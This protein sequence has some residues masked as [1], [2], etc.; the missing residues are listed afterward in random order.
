MHPKLLDYYNR[1][2]VYM[3]EMS[4][5]FAREHP[6]VAK[7]LGMHG[8]EVAD[9][10]VE[11]LIE[12]FCMMS[13]RMQI[14]L[15]AEFPRLTQ[16]LL[17]VIY[18]SYVAPTPSI[19]VAQ[20]HPGGSSGSL[21]RGFA[22][23]RDTH[24]TAL[25]AQGTSTRCL[26]RTTQEVT[27][28]PLEI[29]AA[30]LTGVPPDIP[31]LARY[32][33]GHVEVRGAIRLKLA[34]R[35]ALNFSS[36]AGLD[37]LPIYLSGDEQVATHLFELLH[38]SA[39]A[40][41]IAEPGGFASPA[42]AVT[43]RPVTLEGFAP[44]QSA[45]PLQW[46]MFHGHNLLQEY[47][48]CP[49]RFYFFALEQLAAGLAR[50]EGPQAELVILLS[51]STDKLASL[52]DASQFALFCTPAINLFPGHVDKLQVHPGQT[53]AHLVPKRDRPLDYE[54]HSIQTLVGRHG[55]TSQPL[56]F[57]PLYQT[58]NEDEGNHG[59]YFSLR[60]QVR[61]ASDSTRKYGTRTDYIG[62][63]AFVSLV[64][65]HEAPY[66]EP[67]QQLSVELML[68]NRDLPH[69]VPR[70][71]RDDL[72]AGISAPLAGTGM[73]RPP[74]A[75]RA[76]LADGDMAW[77]LIRQLNF[78]YLPLKDLDSRQGGQGLRDLL[79]LFVGPLD[80]A[81]QRQVESVLSSQ[82][83]GIF[84]RLPGNGPLLYGRGTKCTI[85]VDEEGFS[86]GSPF[87]FG[88]ILEHYLARHVSANSFTHTELVTSQRGVIGTWPA[89]LGTRGTV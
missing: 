64:D 32:V 88:V 5:E 85:T 48:V 16:R 25:R 4:G 56:T 6:K 46:N 42:H 11:R 78:N 79:R 1:E 17:E 30:S 62:T 40:T 59:R 74:S 75:P 24:L 83:E 50:I 2:L 76:P 20:F 13:A 55:E 7:R 41:L 86:G 49:S 69:L 12:A 82:V 77:R 53:E 80:L 67:M 15:D 21:N 38:G 84:K 9:P 33:P 10:Y 19:T 35:D 37:R 52:V 57:R 89:R 43:H 8:I 60:R 73:I 70:N 54:V 66:H 72:A 22:I 31:E 44:E 28:W 23:A 27:L 63:E 14:K 71:G 26:F 65:Q 61:R 18:P 47:F 87:L 45:L 51:R 36:L 39:V 68:T 3:R 81:Q 29:A 58:L 34:T